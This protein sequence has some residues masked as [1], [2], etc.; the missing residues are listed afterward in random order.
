MNKE[1][2]ISASILSADFAHLGDDVNKVLAAGADYIHFDVMD[3]H[4]VPNLS[5]GAM[6]CASLRKAGVK[7]P[8]DVHLMVDN[9]EV[10]IEPFAKAGANILT[11]HP[12]TVDNV[13]AVIAKIKAAGMGAGL[14]FNPDRPVSISDVLISQLDMILLMSVF[15]GF[16]GQ[17]FIP[18][19]LQ[20]I[21]EV[22]ERLS[23]MEVPPF[24][25]VDGGVKVDNIADIAH[26]GADFFVVGSA[27]FKSGDYRE[28][29]GLLR[30]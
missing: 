1:R 30:A 3:H 8:I 23:G 28:C 6:V 24:L 18:E 11:F 21:S 10:Y 26:A 12:E 5:I 7:A 9:P 19:S 27:L 17:A 29:V 14:A 22:R 15:P 25:A 4:F 16:G 2:I 13:E 20:K